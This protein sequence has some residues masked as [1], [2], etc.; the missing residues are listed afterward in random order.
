[1]KK[2]L[3][4]IFLTLELTCCTNQ[5][6]KQETTDPDLAINR[7]DTILNTYE[8]V[9][10]TRL[11]PHHKLILAIKSK[12]YDHKLFIHVYNLSDTGLRLVQSFDS[13]DTQFGET[14]PEFE[15]F[16]SDPLI[17]FKIH[18]G[19]GARGSNL[20]Y[21]VFIQEPTSHLLTRVR[22]TDGKPNL[23]F[24]TTRQ[25]ITSTAFWAGTS[26]VDYELKSDSLVP[27]EGVDV[28]FKPPNWTVREYYEFDSFGKQ[29]TVR[30]DSVPDDREGLYSRE[31]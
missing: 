12:P 7:R 30:I 29:H 20:F 6:L 8:F 18:S 1:M 4:L 23:T 22:N 26:F 11:W 14:T 3:L 13:L 2:V 5:D 17:D 31:K 27:T 21:Y 10:S 25:T 9:D 16:N 15:N 24:D 19:T 28:Y